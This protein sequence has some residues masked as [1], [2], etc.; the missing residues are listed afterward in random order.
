MAE[1]LKSLR[2]GSK[3]VNQMEVLVGE[4]CSLQGVRDPWKLCPVLSQ[5]PSATRREREASFD[6]SHVWQQA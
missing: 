5:V 3:M 1:D 4:A 2:Q 6:E